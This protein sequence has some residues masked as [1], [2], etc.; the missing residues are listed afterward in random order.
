MGVLLVAGGLGLGVGV[1]V[2]VC[3][4]PGAVFVTV[5]PGAVVVLVFDG[6]GLT[7]GFCVAVCGAD[8]VARDEG[9][10]DGTGRLADGLTGLS[11]TYGAT[12]APVSAEGVGHK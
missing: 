2:T 3:V 9:D 12:I 4:G 8:V 1:L 10:L 11:E 7:V 5:G 6:E